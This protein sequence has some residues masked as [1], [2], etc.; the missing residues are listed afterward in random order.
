M[1]YLIRHILLIFIFIVSASCSNPQRARPEIENGFL[2]LSS[3]DFEEDGLVNLKGQWEF[4]WEK[5]LDPSDFESNDS[6]KAEYIYVPSGWANQE[7]KSYP[8][9]GY[10]TYRVKI[11]VPDKELDYNFIFISIF[12]SAKLWVNGSLCFERGKVAETREESE[13][14]FITEYHSPINYES[15]R[16]TMEVIIQVA[17]FDYG[18]PAGGLRRRVAFGPDTQINAERL[19]AY[20]INAFLIGISLLMAIYHIFLFLFRRNELS[21]LVFALLSLVLTF[22]TVFTSGMFNELFSY[23]GYF[24][25]GSIGPSLF[26]PLTVLFFYII[27]KE[28]VHKQAV[29]A[30]MIIGMIFWVIY[31]AGSTI[32][33]GKILTIFLINVALP[34]AYLL[35]Y[36]L[37][38]ALIRRRE[39]SILSYLGLL[40]Q[41]STLVHDVLFANGNIIGIGRYISS[42]GFVAL[43]IMQSLVLA[44]MFSR[45]YRHKVNLSQNLEKM[46]EE[47]TKTIDEQ[48]AVLKRQNLDLQ[49][50]KEEIEAQTEMVNQ[51]N[52]EITDSLDY[53][54]KIQSAVL[55]P[56]QYFHEIL[57]D[58]FIYFKPRDI[59]SGDFYWIK[60]V[61]RYVILAAADCTGHGVPGAFMSMLGMSYL[62][63]IVQ[64]RGITQANQ[65]LNELRRQIR[66]SLRQHGQ[67]E[68]SKDGIDMALCVLDEKN[69]ALQYAGANNP[70][71][72]IRDNNG[73][74]ELTEYKPDRM[75]LGYYQGRFQTFTNQD[76]QLEYGDVIYLFSDGFI[77]QKG[78]REGKKFLSKNFK[79]L[80]MEIYE[81]PMQDQQMILDT[82]FSDWKGDYPQVDDVLVIGVRV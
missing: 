38:K 56:E 82:T 50:Q 33:M 31:L 6:I 29:Y 11:K 77:D 74:P 62:N 59:V 66:N 30:F 37:I 67:P 34:S 64:T 21:Y 46:V 13:P 49:S 57:N 18:G 61:N 40:I 43:I 78:G 42:E 12:A 3:W 73:G 70:L 39:G 8:E 48:K 14:A 10:A 79:K 24:R 44:Q 22:W 80:L 55:P 68:E 27:Y 81:E 9:L 72:L 41:Y 19:K 36:P 17:D 45:T 20:S 75:P 35:G 7:G 71:Y 32:L 2:D 51:R 63:E 26:P 5:L 54:M 76:I 25:F 60:Q 69:K 4:Y 47:R 15:N 16:D 1:K 28:E 23:T 53:A 58:V 65:V 52:E